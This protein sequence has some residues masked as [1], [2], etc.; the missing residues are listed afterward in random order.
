MGC[1]NGNLAVILGGDDLAETAHHILLLQSLND[2]TLELGGTQ[3]ATVSTGRCGEDIGCIVLLTEHLAEVLLVGVGCTA[4]LLVRRS[5]HGLA[6]DGSVHGLVQ[7][8]LD[9]IPALHA[10]NLVGEVVQ[11]LLHLGI[12]G[13]VLGRQN[14]VAITARVEEGLHALPQVCALFTQFRNSHC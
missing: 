11:I 9:G 3:I 13:I 8:G 12:G 2:L 6:G 4:D 1:R 14:T 7:L 5:G 10:V